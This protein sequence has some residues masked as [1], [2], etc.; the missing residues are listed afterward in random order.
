MNFKFN[1]EEQGILDMLH[2]LR[3]MEFVLGV[4]SNKPD[5]QV[6]K[7]CQKHFGDC[8]TVAVGSQDRQAL[9]PAPDPLLRA[10]EE[11]HSDAAHTVYIGD[12][13][14]DVET[15]ANAGIPCISVL[16]GFRD[17]DEIVRAGGKVF[18]ERAAEIPQL[19]ARILAN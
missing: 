18:V 17:K 10:M 14:V 11:L 1:E 8:I 19:A 6:K 7:L 3:K 13:D 12:S 5:A 15:A 2:T 16:W 4:V 9:K